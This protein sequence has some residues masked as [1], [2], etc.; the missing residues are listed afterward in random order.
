MRIT[1][2]CPTN[3]YGAS[4]TR[5]IY[6]P[7]GI[8]LVA[9]LVKDTFPSWQVE[10]ID[11]ELY[12]K[13]ELETRV[14]GTDILGLSA[15]TNN[16]QN[17]IALANYA[18]KSGTRKVV[19]GGPHASAVLTIGQ[20]KIPMAELVLKNQQ[21]IDA[22][23]V[24]AGEEGFLNYAI[25]CEKRTP[26]YTDVYNLFW[27]A[28]DGRILHNQTHFPTKPP[29][30]TDMDF[31]L[32]R[33]DEY[34]REHKKEF[35]AMPEKYV[36]GF[37]HVG[38]AWREKL[39]CSFCDIPYPLNNYQAPG[40]FWRDIREARQRLG[41]ESFKDYGDCLTGNSERVK[42]LLEARPPDLEDIAIS[43][44]GR[45]SEITEETADLLQKLN[46]KYIYVGFDSGDNR[47]L[48]SMQEGYTVKA[49][50][51]AVEKLERRGINITGSLILGAA[52]ESE[53]TIA[54]TE[55]F[56]KRV[57]QYSNVTQLHCAL[58]TPF[59]G[60]PIG[61]TFLESFPAYETRDVWDTEETERLWVKE[62]CQASYEYIEQKAREINNLNPSK[63]KRYFGLKE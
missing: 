12:S 63:R 6:Y 24:Y 40:R 18:K 36:E 2:V 13:S 29:R 44:Y 61:K 3:Y 32:M 51:A 25:A 23:I 60:A 7:M 17:C 49:N 30:F 35:P 59:P 50:L 21:S 54:H 20:K 11:G 14:Q 46:V 19:V 27:K 8:L 53:E 41:I 33:F 58:L 31:S 42:A 56:A 55:Q 5:G 39:G 9:S 38:C 16:Y 34:W 22:A 57:A 45:S 52:G 1:L 37:T 26:A 28:E 10:A 43:C 47:M 15:N 48:K 4:A 62:Q